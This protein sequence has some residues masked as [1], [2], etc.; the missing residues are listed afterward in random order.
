MAASG[1]GTGK[2]G[3]LNF[4][5]ALVTLAV[6]A[7]VLGYLLFTSP[8]RAVELPA[9][10]TLPA[11]HEPPEQLGAGE[12]I[13][14]KAGKPRPRVA[15]IMDDIGMNMAPLSDIEAIGAPVAVAVLPGLR[16]STD[17]ALAAKAAGMEVLLHLPMQPDGDSLHG[18]GPG[19][20]LT[21]MTDAE[22]SEATSQGLESVPGA[23]GVNNHMGSALTRDPR[24]MKA[25][26]GVLKER[27]LYFVDSRTTSG[28]AALA[29]ARGLGVRARGRDVFLDDIDDPARIREQLEKLVAK[30]ARDGVAVGIGH[31][32]PATLAVLAE[33]LPRL[34]A[35]GIDVVRVSEIVR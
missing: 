16:H 26:M 6:T 5:L 21:G 18:L 25:V 30:A 27:G 31:P 23:S 11:K 10:P 3:W 7:F 22:L 14:P 35:R 15:V 33:E 17:A 1:P 32:R 4:L 8:D 13:P 12:E 28:S 34:K 2:G 20:L 29:E 9:G 24:A 19:A